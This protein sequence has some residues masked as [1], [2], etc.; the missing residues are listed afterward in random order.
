MKNDRNI[1]Y[2]DGYCN[3]CNGWVRFITKW[4]KK[5]TF[6]FAPLL[7]D[8]SNK[9]H[10]I[11]S[12]T[13][14]YQ[15]KN[16]MYTKSTAVLYILWDLGGLWTL[17]GLFFAVPAFLRNAVYDFVAKNRYKWAGRRER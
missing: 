14:M 17:T 9:T 2:F 15:R 4:D 11:P 10:T 13:I 1:V 5:H 6:E 7:D 3:L 16:K 12:D 8:K